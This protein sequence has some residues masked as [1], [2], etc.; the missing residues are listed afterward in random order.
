MNKIS[1]GYRNTQ[2]TE[3]AREIAPL[4]ISIS[5]YLEI[6]SLHFVFYDIHKNDLDL[7]LRPQVRIY[8]YDI[9]FGSFFLGKTEIPT[10]F[11]VQNFMA[12][13]NAVTG[14]NSAVNS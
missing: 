10:D 1:L 13:Y 3:R 2:P 5:T 6:T 12:E 14:L 4:S 9:Q 8:K 7:K 11:N